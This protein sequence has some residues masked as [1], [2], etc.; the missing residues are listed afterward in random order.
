MIWAIFTFIIPIVASIVA[1]SMT[2]VR[3]PPGRNM[4]ITPEVRE[5]LVR[6]TA[7]IETINMLTPNYH[8]NRA[9]NYVLQAYIRIGFTP[10]GGTTP[11]QPPQQTFRVLS[12]VESLSNAWPNILVL[13]LIA[14][15][16]LI[17]TYML[18]VKQET[19]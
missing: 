12:I 17:A 9:S 6:R 8:F 18:F 10:G 15:F 13:F 19:R 11:G 7:I 5:E 16:T 3:I 2:P 4:T 14:V 1:F